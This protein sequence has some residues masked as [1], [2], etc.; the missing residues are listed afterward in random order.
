MNAELTILL[1]KKKTALE[2]RDFLSGEFEPVPLADVMAVLRAREASG[3]IKLVAEARSRCRCRKEEGDD[4]LRSAAHAGCRCAHAIAASSP[5]SSAGSPRCCWSSRS[6]SSPRRCST[7]TRSPFDARVLR[8]LRRADDP[9]TP[10]GP[11]WLRSGALDITALGSPTVLGLV[12]LAI[13]GF[14]LLQRMA[15][16]AAFVFVATTGGW[17]V[18]SLLKDL[19]QRARPEVV[20]HLRDVMSLSFPSGHA[21]TSAAVYLTLGALSMRVADRRVTK[22]YCMAVAMGVSVLVGASRVFLGV[23]Y[24]DRRA[25]RLA[26][27]DGAGRLPAGR[28]SGASSAR[29]GSAR[30]PGGV[31]WY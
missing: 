19:F 22:F 20:P 10:I 1:G 13:C 16:T 2:I 17:L 21:M 27:R 11:A 6:S 23:H 30:E 26:G 29:P 18:N 31:G 14:L 9:S 5:C 12:T 4:S 25:G 24:P 28:S 8:S 15:R 3:Q 7:A